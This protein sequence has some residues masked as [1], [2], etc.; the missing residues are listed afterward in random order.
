MRSVFVAGTDTGVGKTVVAG[1]LAR[2]AARAGCRTGVFK[3]FAAGGTGDVAALGAALADAGAAGEAG[4][5]SPA[6]ARCSYAFAAPASPYAAARLEGMDIDIGAV[7]DRLAQM[8]REFEAVVV[9]GIGGA[10]APIRKDYFV[11]DLIRDMAVPAIIVTANR[12][13]APGHSA[14]AASCC[15]R[16]GAHVAGF[17]VNRIE[18]Y[19]YE[20]AALRREIRNVTGL[21]VLASV[22]RSAGGGG[23]RVRKVDIPAPDS[24]GAPPRLGRG[25]RRSARAA[26]DASKRGDVDGAAR[27]MFGPGDGGAWEAASRWRLQSERRGRKRRRARGA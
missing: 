7:L 13:D 15:R 5:G 20:G 4:R 27:V 3:P 6:P 11:A 16:R 24:G 14:M 19:G 9:E 17:V 26:I 1:A 2:T 21:P 8:R 12:F 10:M 22:K 25:A 18:E 23:R